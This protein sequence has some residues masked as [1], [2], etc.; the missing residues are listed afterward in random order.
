MSQSSHSHFQPC[1][2]ALMPSISQFILA[3]ILLWLLGCYHEQFP[4][5]LRQTIVS[6][7]G[8]LICPQL[9]GWTFFQRHICDMRQTKLNL[10]SIISYKTISQMSTDNPSRS[11]LISTKEHGWGLSC[12][13]YTLCWHSFLTLCS[14][15]TSK[16]RFKW[17]QKIR[18]TAVNIKHWM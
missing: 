14:A 7:E 15:H 9:Q 16:I 3:L 5:H 4:T 18:S 13:G 10:K 17:L 1:L 2:K 8:N 6:D 11:L 12:Y